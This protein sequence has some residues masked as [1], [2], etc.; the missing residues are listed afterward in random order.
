MGL[1][2]AIRCFVVAVPARFDLRQRR[3]CVDVTRASTVTQIIHGVV[4][5]C[6]GGVFRV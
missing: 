2:A 6:G 5:R 1:P 3:V 4:D